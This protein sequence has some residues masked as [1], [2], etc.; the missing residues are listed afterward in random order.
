MS[1]WSHL[2]DF[3]VIWGIKVAVWLWDMFFECFEDG[4]HGLIEVFA[5]SAAQF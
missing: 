4:S 3:F 2:G 5:A 1:F